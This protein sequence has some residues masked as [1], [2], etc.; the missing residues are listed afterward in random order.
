MKDFACLR[1]AS[2]TGVTLDWISGKT[3]VSDPQ[4]KRGVIGTLDALRGPMMGDAPLMAK[5]EG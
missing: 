1:H 4:T 3:N 5:G 2:L